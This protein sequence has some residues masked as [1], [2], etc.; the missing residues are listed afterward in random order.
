MILSGLPWVWEL[1]WGSPYPWEW[2]S[3][4][5]VGIHMGIPTKIMWE[6]DG[7]G[8]RNSTPTATLDTILSSQT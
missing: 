6:W 3:D 7:N 4:F 2:E 8:D 5:L 1:P